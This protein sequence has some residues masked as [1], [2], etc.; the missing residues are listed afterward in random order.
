M[1]LGFG[2][3]E[4]AAVALFHIVNHATF[5]AA[6]FMTAGIVDHETGTRDLRRLGGLRS[7]MP[8]TFTARCNRHAVDGRDSP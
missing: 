2:T 7:A 1:L 4:A 5:K 6:L 3:P 8:V